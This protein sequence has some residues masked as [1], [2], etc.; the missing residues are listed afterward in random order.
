VDRLLGTA[1]GDVVGNVSAVV[2]LLTERGG[3]ISL[4]ISGIRYTHRYVRT[5][6]R[7][8]STKGVM[9]NCG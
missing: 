9:S 7:G 8:E 1:D 4:A 3:Q 6:I 5:G 2:H